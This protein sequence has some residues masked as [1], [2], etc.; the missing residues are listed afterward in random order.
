M[1]TVGTM[2]VADVRYV[3]ELYPR[4]SPSDE[5]IDRYRAALD[6]LPPITVARDGVLV[7]GYH[8]WQAHLRDG[9][10]TIQAEHLGDLSDAEILREAYRRN[11]THGHQLSAR[12]KRRAADHLYR[13]LPGTAA[14]RY[15]EIA[16]VL[17]LTL[18]SA[19]DYA[20][21]AKRDEA[22]EQKARAIDLWQDCWTQESIA[23]DVGAGRKTVGDWVADFRQ[24]RRF[25]T[26][27]ESRQHFDVWSFHADKDSDTT[28]FG[29]IPEQV[30]ENLLWLFTEPG[31]VVVDPFAGSGTTIEVGKRMGR[32]VWAADR[33][34]GT[35][36]PNLPIH[37]HDA[38]AG[39]PDGAPQKPAL[40]LLD[41]PY[42]KQAAGRYSD[43]AADLGN[44]TLDEFMA[45]WGAVL[46]G[47]RSARPARVAFIVS[48][49]QDGGMKDGS[50]V[51]LA[52]LMAQSAIDRGWTIERRIIVAYSTQQATGQQVESAR[53]HR[54]L[55][56]L[57]RDLVVLS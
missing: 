40:V 37:Q 44:Q 30:V 8:R 32:R 34:S 10:D 22:A 48:P 21:E 3:R 26:A 2:K 12:D 19:Q 47:V 15:A 57:Y 45:S 11:A 36:Y 4:L 41:P 31:D 27:P 5:V 13:T 18:R 24:D 43:D 55:L 39:W 54:R 17:G 35:K 23:A 33:I 20:A 49:A 28:Y 29:R 14:E 51:D 25:A 9:I 1:S 53:E 46:D 38:T 7:D 6:R 52:F 16:A 42:W 50:V 56:K